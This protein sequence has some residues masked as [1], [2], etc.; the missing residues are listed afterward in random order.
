MEGPN[1]PAKHGLHE[2]KA[3]FDPGKVLQKIQ[4]QKA[5]EDAPQPEEKKE[6]MEAMME[7]PNCPAKH[8]LHEFKAEFDP[9]KVLQKIQ[10]QKAKEDAPQ[11]EEKKEEMEAMME[12]PNCPA[13]HG[14]HEFKAEADGFR[15]DICGLKKRKGDMMYG[16][17]VCKYDV[18]A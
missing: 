6:E 17:R 12:G 2:F 13:K 15:C 7:G 4:R 14:L 10:R 16:C 18:C 1:C 8:G 3:E 11:P 9:G 5:K